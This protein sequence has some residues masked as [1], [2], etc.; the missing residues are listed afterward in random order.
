VIAGSSLS[1]GCFLDGVEQLGEKLRE[2][3]REGG[4]ASCSM[5]LAGEYPGW[6]DEAG[7]GLHTEITGLLMASG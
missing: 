3:V 4:V 5:N 1:F 2:V 6:C 7:A